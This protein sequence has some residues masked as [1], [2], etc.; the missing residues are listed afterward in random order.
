MYLCPRLGPE[1]ILDHYP[2]DYGPFRPAIEDE[3]SAVLRWLRRRKLIRSRQLVE[4]YSGRRRGRILDVGCSTGLFLHEMQQAGWQATGVEPNAAAAEY[5]RR[6]FGL[7]VFQGMLEDAPCSARSLDAVTFWDVL[8]H[9]FSPAATLRQVAGLLAPGGLV[10]INI[11]NWDSPDRRLFGPLWVGYDPP[12]HL[13]VFTRATLTA[14]LGQAGLEPV[15][16][17]CFMPSYFT[18]AFS[19]DYWL[20]ARAPRWAPVLSR[21]LHLPGLRFL[22]EPAFWLANAAGRG[23][24]IAVFA[25]R[26]DDL[27]RD[28]QL[29]V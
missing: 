19:A 28:R 1:E 14:L 3:S 2:P 21:G 25:R 18:F 16:W 10:A 6:R 29:E 17:H 24:V 12:R 7:E 23:G 26:K 22:F 4:R 20:A 5:A 15:A 27:P 13:Y 9:T 8:E 11:P